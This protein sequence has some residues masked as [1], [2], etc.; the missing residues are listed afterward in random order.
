MGKFGKLVGQP[1]KRDGQLGAPSETERVADPP[2]QTAIQWMEKNHGNWVTAPLEGTC[3]EMGMP[4]IGRLDRVLRET[5]IDTHDKWLR[6]KGFDTEARVRLAESK[7]K[8][9]KI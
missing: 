8:P 1:R 4:D 6:K 3:K 7:K 9:E 2:G 5:L